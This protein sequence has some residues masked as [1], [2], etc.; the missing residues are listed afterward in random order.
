M[1]LESKHRFY[2]DLSPEEQEHWTSELIRC[3]DV[4]QTT[5]I[6]NAAYLHHP[7][8]YLFCENDQAL[9]LFLQQSMVKTIE[10]STGIS[11]EKA[12]CDAGH[13]PF[14]S[15]PNTLLNLVDKIVAV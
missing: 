14:L 6:T 5:P 10:E 11:I 9:P 12:T 2:N 4:T 8:T 1:M 7:V 3:P 13:S 15:Q